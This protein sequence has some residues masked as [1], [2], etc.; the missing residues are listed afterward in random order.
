MHNRRTLVVLGV[1]VLF[2]GCALDV[3][4]EPGE[5]SETLGEASQA[6]RQPKLDICHYDEEGI[7]HEISIAQAAYYAHLNHGDNLIG[8]ETCDG[9]DNDCNGEVDDALA[10]LTCGIGACQASAAACVNG[11]PQTC[12]PGAPSPETC[13]GID[14]D[15]NGMVDD[16]AEICGDGIDNDC[17][18]MVDSDDTADCCVQVRVDCDPNS[19]ILQTLCGAGP[20]VLAPFAA[21]NVSYVSF[22]AGVDKV[23]LHHCPGGT[24]GNATLDLM[25]STN[26]CTLE[27]GC[28]DADRW[29]DQVCSIDIFY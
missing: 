9:I 13:D 10:P 24:L 15:C 16:S 22:G 17:D 1:G 4:S 2:G 11:Q 6:I 26:L 27:G 12:V 18:G 8:A 7:G 28:C 20:H 25:Q 3:P 5:A 19:T 29:N 21:G 23:T 14:N